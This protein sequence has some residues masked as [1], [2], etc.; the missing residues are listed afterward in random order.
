MPKFKKQRELIAYFYCLS[1][2]GYK[3]AFI[4]YKSVL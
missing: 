4:Y 2:F 1:N 3:D